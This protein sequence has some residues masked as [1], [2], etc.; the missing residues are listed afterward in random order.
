MT[1]PFSLAENVI[2]F[3]PKNKKM[4]T[5]FLYHLIKDL[6]K[7]TEYKRHWTE[8]TN[9]DVLIPIERLQMRFEDIVKTNHQKIEVLKKSRVHASMTRDLLLSRLISGKL[10]VEALN[11]QFPPSMQ[12]EQE[13]AH[14]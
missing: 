11:I 1:K 10:P 4:P 9:R 6:A 3:F 13:N 7:T 12:T 14:A 8:L 2:P 5:Y